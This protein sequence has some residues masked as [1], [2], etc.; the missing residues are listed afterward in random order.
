MPKKKYIPQPIDTSSIDVPESLLLLGEYLAKN[1]HEVWAQQRMQDG[2]TYGKL[3]DADK[4]TH[5]DLVPYEDLPDSEKV[6]DRSV[7]METLKVILSLGYR[8]VKENP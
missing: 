7:S 8:I 6:Y 2:W 1:T 5:P 4:K 3:R